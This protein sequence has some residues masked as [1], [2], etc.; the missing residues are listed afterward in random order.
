MK[1]TPSQS[2]QEQVTS[3]VQ[4]LNKSKSRVLV[5]SYCYNCFITGNLKTKTLIVFPNELEHKGLI[6]IDKPLEHVE[7]LDVLQLYTQ[8]NKRK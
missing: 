6:A 4:K 3:W 7:L 1:A 8:I 2:K 5:S